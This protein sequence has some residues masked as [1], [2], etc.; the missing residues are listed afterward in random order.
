LKESHEARHENPELNDDRPSKK[1]KHLSCHNESEYDEQ[2]SDEDESEIEDYSIHTQESYQ[3]DSNTNSSSTAS[4]NLPERPSSAFAH[5][6]I[7][8]TPRMLQF[9]PEMNLG[10]IKQ[11][12][13]DNW[14]NMSPEQR[15]PWVTMAEQDHENYNRNNENFV[16]NIEY[17][18]NSEDDSHG[19]SDYD[20]DDLLNTEE[21]SEV[22]ESNQSYIQELIHTYNNHKKSQ[23]TE[24]IH[25]PSYFRSEPWVQ[26]SKLESSVENEELVPIPSVDASQCQSEVVFQKDLSVTEEIVPEHCSLLDTQLDVQSS[27]QETIPADTYDYNLSPIEEDKL[28]N[29]SVVSKQ[30]NKPLEIQFLIKPYNKEKENI[31]VLSENK[32]NPSSPKSTTPL[33]PRN[34]NHNEPGSRNIQQDR[35]YGLKVPV[36]YIVACEHY[37]KAAKLDDKNKYGPQ[38]RQTEL[39]KSI[40][41]KWKQM[42]RSERKM[43]ED[44]AKTDKKRYEKEREEYL[45]SQYECFLKSYEG[46]PLNDWLVKFD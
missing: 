45:T 5:F 29:Q 12:L 16:P 21:D 19:S 44:M 11:I 9:Y 20:F 43:W 24:P 26:S 32:G 27:P 46:I 13:L 36:P 37:Q 2:E 35:R 38:S 25:T 6:I 14:N 28:S 3:Y 15:I 8:N 10:N 17:N 42:A 39:N 34:I 33:Q 4:I 31:H 30:H 7:D 18:N 23:R 40:N 41:D 1:S 22:D